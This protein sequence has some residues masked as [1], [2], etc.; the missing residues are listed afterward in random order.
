PRLGR[1]VRV[2]AAPDPLGPHQ[3]DRPAEHRQVP[4]LHPAAAVPDRPSPA[5]RAADDIGRGLDLQPPLV[6]DLGLGAH[7][8]PVDAEQHRHHVTTV[9]HVSGLAFRSA[10][11]DKSQKREAPGLAGRPTTNREPTSP[12]PTLHRVEPQY[13]SI[14]YAERLAEND[15]VASVGS[16]GDSYDCDDPAVLLRSA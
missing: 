10:T 4:D 5:T 12:A 13:L 11:F 15:I 6:D 14:R 1:T 8:H 2:G 16:K 9:E 3:H 7:A